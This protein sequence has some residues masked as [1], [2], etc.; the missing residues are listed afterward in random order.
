MSNNYFSLVRQEI[1]PLIP[2]K[3]D[4]ALEIGCGTGNTLQWLKKCDFVNSTVGFELNQTAADEARVRC[5]EII[6]GNIE[7]QAQLLTA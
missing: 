6:V 5:D 2:A 7:Q 3:V 1:A 4:V